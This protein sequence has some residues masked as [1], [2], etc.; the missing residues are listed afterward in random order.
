MTGRQ[1][2]VTWT[3]PSL[4]PFEMTTQGLSKEIVIRQIGGTTPLPSPVEMIGATLV[5]E[6]VEYQVMDSW[7]NTDGDLVCELNEAV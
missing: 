5:V 2:E 3:D 6:D 1:A 4:D 7:W